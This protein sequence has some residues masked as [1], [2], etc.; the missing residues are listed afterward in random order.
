MSKYVVHTPIKGHVPGKTIQPGTA[1]KPTVITIEDA[2]EAASLVA[3]GAVSPVPDAEDAADKP[4]KA[5][6][7]K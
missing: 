6:A 4:A 2:A 3:C 1:D 7:K 5:P